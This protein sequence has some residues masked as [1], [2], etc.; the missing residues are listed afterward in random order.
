MTDTT[1]RLDPLTTV[2]RAALCERAQRVIGG[3]LSHEHP[4]ELIVLGEAV[5]CTVV[6]RHN[7]TPVLVVEVYVDDIDT[8][9]EQSLAAVE[10]WVATNSALHPLTALRIDRPRCTGLTPCTLVAAHSIVL[11]A[12]HDVDST[13]FGSGDAGVSCTSN[14]ASTAGSADVFGAITLDAVLGEVLDALV[15][16]ARR[17]RSQL[18]AV[19]AEPPLDETERWYITPSLSANVASPMP[20]STATP[21]DVTNVEHEPVDAPPYPARATAHERMPQDSASGSAVVRQAGNRTKDEILAELDALIGIDTVKKGL[22]GFV[23]A[24]E[25]ARRRAEAGLAAVAPSPHLIFVGN[26]GTGKTTVA[27]LLGELYLALGMLP[28]GHLVET[29]RAG[30]VAGYVGQTALKTRAVC[31][32]ALGGVLFI[33]EAYALAGG[34]GDFGQEA[35]DTLLT[36]M[37]THRNEF[38]LVVAGYPGEMFRFIQSNPGLRSRF[39][40]HYFFDDFETDELLMILEDL[41]SSKDYDFN[42]EA[43]VKVMRLLLSWKSHPG[44][45]NAREIRNLFHEIVRNHAVEIE[46]LAAEGPVDTVALRTITP[47]AV[48]GWHG[49][50]DSEASC[51]ETRRDTLHPGYL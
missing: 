5:T 50:D 2:V 45:G 36:F 29:D 16:L 30:L 25:T 10:R 4:L 48:P 9:A 38:A 6:R 8:P 19:L 43:R 18:R 11:S 42:D 12:T 26:P 28:S 17:S 40:E 37:E 27:R 41:A 15:H 1:L 46:R 13:H 39:D 14:T 35:I 3:N 23:S 47:E 49:D 21:L 24:Q 32:Q 51:P 7:T 33:D 34:D 44:L 31:E 20:A 22:R